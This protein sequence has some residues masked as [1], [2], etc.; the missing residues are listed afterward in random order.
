MV[1]DG[2][3]APKRSILPSPR[4]SAPDGI[5]R[6]R[7]L[8]SA[9]RRPGALA[10]DG[11]PTRSLYRIGVPG[12]MSPPLT[13][14]ARLEEAPRRPSVFLN[15][16]DFRRNVPVDR[17]KCRALNAVRQRLTHDSL[18]QIPRFAA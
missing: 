11:P 12:S 7:A 14:L 10:C 13:G 1:A 16:E 5:G 3:V 9:A 8:R 18:E 17:R 6:R 4:K 15:A 2:V